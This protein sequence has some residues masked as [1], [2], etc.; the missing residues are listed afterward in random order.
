MPTRPL[1]RASLKLQLQRR[2]NWMTLK[3]RANGSSPTR[4]SLG[5]RRTGRRSWEAYARA[6]SR[7][8]SRCPCHVSHGDDV[9]TKAAPGYAAVF[10]ER[11]DP[12]AIKIQVQESPKRA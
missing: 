4:K 6:V 5:Q 8:L 12:D 3:P 1:K 7:A 9:A 2:R 10:S 11:R